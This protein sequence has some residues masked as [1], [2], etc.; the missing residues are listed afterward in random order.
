MIACVAWMNY[1][2]DQLLCRYGFFPVIVVH[3]LMVVGN[4]DEWMIDLLFREG[5]TG[6]RWDDSRLKSLFFVIADKN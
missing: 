2:D 6:L 1:I 4:K 3:A 5:I